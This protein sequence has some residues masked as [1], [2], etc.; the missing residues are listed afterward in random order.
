[1]SYVG[2]RVKGSHLSTAYKSVQI[3]H[4]WV[5]LYQRAYFIVQVPL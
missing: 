5:E 2:S 4:T 3:I 1:M